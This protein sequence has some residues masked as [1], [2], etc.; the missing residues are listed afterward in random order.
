M[1]QTG[2]EVPRYQQLVLSTTNA[3]RL[4]KSQGV[5]PSTPLFLLGSET[6]TQRPRFP[7][8]TG[9]RRVLESQ[10]Q[11]PSPF[12]FNVDTQRSLQIIMNTNK[13]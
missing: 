10:I 12:R 1:W 13:Y 9:E 8:R 4:V 7:R 2:S 5:I 3:Q 11:L 6:R